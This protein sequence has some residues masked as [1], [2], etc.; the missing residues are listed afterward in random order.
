MLDFSGLSHLYR[1]ALLQDVLAF[2]EA[3]SLDREHGGY[4]TCLERS[5]AVF[6]T[7]KFVWLQN[8]QVWTFSMLYN[9]LEK[10]ETWLDMA[11][12][13]A[14]FLARHGRDPDGN[15]FFALDR[16]GRPLIQPYN[17]FSD[18]F[19]AMAFSQYALA[20]GEQWAQA[21]ARQA[22]DNVLR[23]KENP[24]GPYNKVVPGARP[25]KALAIPMILANLSLE[26]DW[27]LP[28]GLLDQVIEATLKEVMGDF[29][30]PERL[31]L[32][33]HV[34]P[35]GAHVDCMDGRLINPG[36][37]IEAMWFIMDIAHR[38]GDRALIERAVDV[39]LST[40]AFSWD[41]E[42]GGL[43]YFMDA[44]GHPPQQLEWDQKLWWVHLESLVA[45]AMGYALTGREACWTW[46]QKVHEYA[47]PRF[48]DPEYGE[49]FGYLNRRGEP[50]LT[51]K[52]GKWKGC[53][54][55]PRALYLCWQQFEALSK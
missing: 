20:S 30:D 44:D 33:E 50:L 37:G 29:L 51:L 32:Y 53:F 12:S 38:R 26:M 2:W 25:L 28:A 27:L 3:H 49:W 34:A 47:W 52:G 17:I 5:G 10:R 23:R 22:Y 13:G 8:R 15:W 48:A 31:L 42:Y 43:Y 39:V 4:F 35:D 46:Y 1:Q 54:H 18:C 7:D 14:D 6:D 41:R 11:R 36:H 21:V 45:L 16:A 19:A 24:K 55:V 9:R 40:L